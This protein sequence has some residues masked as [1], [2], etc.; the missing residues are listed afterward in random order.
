MSMTAGEPA[1]ARG[2][3]HSYRGAVTYEYAPEADR[4]PDPGEIV[5]SWVAFEEDAAIGKDRPIAIVGRTPDG[6]YAALML[7]SRDHAGDRGWVSIGSGPWDREGR[8]SWLRTDRLLAVHGDAVRREGSV[9]TRE[10][11]DSVVVALGGSAAPVK[12][13][14]LRRLFRRT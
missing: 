7:S 8:V 9:M 4:E 10:V 14:F 6:R 11:Y 3:A 1:P 2:G 12:V 5:W 13:G